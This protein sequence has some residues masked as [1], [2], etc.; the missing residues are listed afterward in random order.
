M[1]GRVDDI[2]GS[3]R[4]RCSCTSASPPAALEIHRRR[5]PL[6]IAVRQD[7]KRIHRRDRRSLPPTRTL[8]TSA[9]ARRNNRQSS[10][11]G[12]GVWGTTDGGKTLDPHGSGRHTVD[13]T[14]SRWIPPDP[15]DRLRGG[16]GPSVRTQP[17]ARPVQNQRR[18]QDLEEGRNTSTPTPASTKCRSIPRTP[19]SFTLHRF[20]GG[21]HGGAITAADRA[22]CSGN[23]LTAAT[24]GRS[25][26]APGWPKPKDGIYGRI[27]L[28]IFRAKPSTIYAQVE[29][30]ASAV[31]AAARRRMAGRHRGGRG[32]ACGESGGVK[33]ARGEAA[34]HRGGRG[35]GGGAAA[36]PTRAAH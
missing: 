16:H 36:G 28:S 32:G 11:I 13:S 20:S 34:A 9:R 2:Q 21:A 25:S 15:E 8:F 29:A 17:R 33:S 30:G 27:A 23:R 10:S 3:E 22:A 31:P 35:G 12:D 26:M 19:R 1:M 5:Q 14:A 6:E 7:A 24:P 4:T 18:R